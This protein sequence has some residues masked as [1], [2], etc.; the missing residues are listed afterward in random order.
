MPAHPSSTI[1]TGSTTRTESNSRPFALPGA[2][3]TAP[4][5]RSPSAVASGSRRRTA[6]ATAASRERGTTTASVPSSLSN[7]AAASATASASPSSSTRSAQGGTPVERTAW[8]AVPPE[9][10][11]ASTW[12]ATTMISAGVR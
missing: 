3:T 11:A 8:A 4:A 5:V 10:P 7:S 12:S 6:S 1:A 2:R 9:P